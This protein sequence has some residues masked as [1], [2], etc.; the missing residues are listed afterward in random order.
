VYLLVSGRC[1]ATGLHTMGTG[2]CFPWL[3]RSVREAD[4]SYPLSVEVK[5]GEAIP[6]LPPYVFM[7]SC[8]IHY[9]QGELYLF[10]PYG[11]R[12]SVVK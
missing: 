6:P 12:Y 11:R 5:N 10:V 3:R 1:P 8:I 2:G 7:A 9:A 4:H